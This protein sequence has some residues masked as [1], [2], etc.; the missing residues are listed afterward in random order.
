[1]RLDKNITVC[2]VDIVQGCTVFVRLSLKHK[3]LGT[4][5]KIVDYL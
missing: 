4:F 1:M 5:Q 2:T 3:E